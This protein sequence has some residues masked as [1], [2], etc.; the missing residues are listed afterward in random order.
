MKEH[1]GYE[2]YK[3]DKGFFS[4]IVGTNTLQVMDFYIRPEYRGGEVL[5]L[6]FIKVNE[7][8]CARGCKYIKGIVR[9]NVPSA[10]KLLKIYKAFG[11]DIIGT[12]E[13]HGIVVSCKVRRG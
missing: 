1:C 8:A 4:Y 10:Y 6:M 12:T 7:I 3:D 2:V 9:A 11:L 13:G 5:P